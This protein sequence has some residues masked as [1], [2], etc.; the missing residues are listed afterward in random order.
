M[1]PTLRAV[2]DDYPPE[3]IGYAEPWIVNPGDELDVKISCTE[4]AYT[5]KVVRLVQGLEGK[6]YPQKK[7]E[8]ITAIPSKLQ[9][10][11][12][13]MAIPGSYAIITDSALTNTT[14]DVNK[15]HISLHFCSYLPVAGHDQC[16]LSTLDC[17]TNSGFAVILNDAGR[18]DLVVGTG[19]NK[20]LVK[21]GFHPENKQWIKLELWISQAGALDFELSPIPT[22]SQ[23]PLQSAFRMT[24]RRL[25]CQFEQ[26][27]I[28]P[29]M[30][31]AMDARSANEST[32]QICAF[33]NG[34]I[35][36][37]TIRVSSG[38]NGAGETVTV[39]YDFARDVHSST[40]ID[41]SGR[42]TLGRV[43][44]SPTRAVTDH[45][46]D[47][48]EE[49]WTKA[50]YGYGAIHFHEDD[51][52]DAGWQTDFRIRVPSVARSGAYSVRVE[53]VNGLAMD[54]VVFFVRP[55]RGPSDGVRRP[56]TGFVLSTFTYLAYANERMYDQSKS[57]KLEH[58]SHDF[59]VRKDWQFDRMVRRTDLGLSLYDVHRDGS[60]V[61]YSSPRR[62]LL[63]MRPDYIHWALH[64]PREFSADLLMIGLLERLGIPYDVL[65]DHDLHISQLEAADDRLCLD[66]YDV[67]I[68]G[69]HPEYPTLES[70]NAYTSHLCRDGSLFYAGGNGFYWVAALGVA[71]AAND[72][73]PQGLFQ[74]CLEVRRGD[75][76]IR[77]YTLPGG[78]R[79]FSSNGQRGTL[80]RSRGRP[81]NLLVGVGSAGEG[82]GPGVPYCRTAASKGGAYAWIFDG[83]EAD[84]IGVDGFGG[85]ASGD[86]FDKYDVAN[87]SPA[88]AV[89]LATS[90]GHSD[91]FGIFIEDVGFPIQN[92]LGSQTREIRS[93]M[94]L[95]EAVGGG[96]VF[97]VG[98]I[99]W[100][101]CVGWNDYDN[102]AARVTGNVLR[103]FLSRKMRGDMRMCFR[104]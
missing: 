65:T 63:N 76:G 24:S 61:V 26:L 87:G 1:G 101:S 73:N 33:F 103:G 70:L 68:A 2:P 50:S 34:R 85:G 5:Y 97:S 92:T 72:T 51:L 22:F 21:T 19:S 35:A 53:A 95:F 100:L 16:I 93:D 29:L 57:S 102:D 30:F 74:G 91:D 71:T 20:E 67:L 98:S 45:E 64:R 43:F 41:T 13:Q 96:H 83:V 58:P 46:W 81:A 104:I 9:E 60:G 56:R 17:T 39:K 3:I 14:K 11:R 89:V 99:N 12:F 75:Q 37:P 52:D 31:A 7:E 8:Q 78:E 4:P 18:V 94:V 36:N 15:V 23:K 44:N 86:E 77:T 6:V 66:Q 47:G 10:G 40:L 79:H 84:L 90:T 62:P 82:L 38:D 55:S 80:W 49:D 54:D 48:S 32:A 25:R 42:S 59:A 88:G 27:K 28:A 69:C